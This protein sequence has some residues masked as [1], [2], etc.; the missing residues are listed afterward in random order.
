MGSR[1]E[2]GPAHT[3][4][5]PD[6]WVQL[7]E[8]CLTESTCSVGPELELDM[9]PE[10]LSSLPLISTLLFTY[11]VRSDLLPPVSLYWLAEEL[12]PAV[13]AAPAP[14]APAPAAPAPAAPAPL[15]EPDPMLAFARMKSSDLDE[16]DGAP[17]VGAPP[18][19]LPLV[20]VALAVSDCRQPVTVTVLLLLSSFWLGA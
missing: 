4:G 7:G 19:S 16:E 18:G 17:A 20:P 3:L 11:F 10:A 6:Y 2:A 14:A 1:H 15:L 8:I 12:E 5:C 13:P 9:A